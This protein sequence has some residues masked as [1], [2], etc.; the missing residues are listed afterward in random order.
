MVVVSAT[1]AD[2]CKIE[3]HTLHTVLIR[4]LKYCFCKIICL[5]SYYYK[6]KL[7]KVIFTENHIYHFPIGSPV[8]GLPRNY[9]LEIWIYC[10]Y[11][12]KSWSNLVKVIN[13]HP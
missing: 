7:Y 9:F 1:K 11:C 8:N 4:N 6:W 3:F 2:G 5:N 13:V 10:E 12:V